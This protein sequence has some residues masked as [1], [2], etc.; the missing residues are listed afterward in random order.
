MN[1]HGSSYRIMDLSD[2]S[3]EN[4]SRRIE[5]DLV[6]VP[7]AAR[8][9]TVTLAITCHFRVELRMQTAKKKS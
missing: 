9:C 4:P 7:L 2:T 5:R 6:V 1:N 8:S 3:N